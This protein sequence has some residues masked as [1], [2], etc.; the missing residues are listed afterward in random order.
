MSENQV[1]NET[2][3]NKS[4]ESEVEDLSD[5]P[6]LEE[7][8]DQNTDQSFKKKSIRIE[9]K[10]EEK[11]LDSEGWLDVL[12]NG[13]LKKFVLTKGL[14]GTPRPERGCLV[15]IKLITKLL[16]SQ[17]VIQSESYDSLDIV[18]GDSDVIQGIDLVIP[19]MDQ[20]EVSRILIKSRFAYGKLGKAPEI[21]PNATLDCELHLLSVEWPEEDM[22]LPIDERIRIGIQSILFFIIIISPKV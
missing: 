2:I 4:D 8:V 22:I 13:D 6:P 18:L 11:E 14:V 7:F 21:P 10:K 19:L 20:K 5:M 12:D 16:D 15:V 3:D 9:D 17:Q 1:L